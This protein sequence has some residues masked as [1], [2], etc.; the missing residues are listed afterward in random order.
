MGCRRCRRGS[1][2]PSPPPANKFAPHWRAATK[3]AFA[4]S[5]SPIQASAPA[6][7]GWGVRAG[8]L[9]G[10]TPRGAVL[11]AGLGGVIA[12]GLGYGIQRG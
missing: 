7:R 3:P 12:A 4:G 11:T 6:R 2:A 5:P 10:G 9:G 8:G 1:K